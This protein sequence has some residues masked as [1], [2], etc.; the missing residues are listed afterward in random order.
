[1]ILSRGPTL[2]VPIGAPSSRRGAAP[3]QRPAVT[4]A[5]AAGETLAEAERRHI[6]AALQASG[7]VV[8][9]P[10]APRRAWA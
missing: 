1:M 7:W 8:G 6:L 2:D 4:A 5:D 3:A 9:G 10:T